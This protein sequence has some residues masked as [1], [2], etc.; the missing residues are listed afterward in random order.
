[1]KP[2]FHPTS[3]G[4]RAHQLRLRCRGLSLNERRG[5]RDRLC[6]T[7]K[8][9][10][11]ALAASVEHTIPHHTTPQTKAKAMESEAKVNVNGK[12]GK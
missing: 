8:P 6:Q 9:L 10:M 3:T 7:N 5:I 2:L 1:M 12:E 4:L 11:S